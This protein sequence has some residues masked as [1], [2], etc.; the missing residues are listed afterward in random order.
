MGERRSDKTKKKTLSASLTVLCSQAT[1]SGYFLST[2]SARMRKLQS[3]Y[4]EVARVDSNFG[5]IPPH[6]GAHHARKHRGQH[7]ALERPQQR[8]PQ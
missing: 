6:H 3:Q 4:E 2:C 7:A 5:S 8:K 1:R